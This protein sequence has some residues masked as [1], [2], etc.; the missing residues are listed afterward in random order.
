MKSALTIHADVRAQQR[1][2]SPLVVDLLLQFGKR[3]HDHAGA[4][5][6]FFDRRAKKDVESYTGGSIGKLSE[7]MDSY[8][9]VS[10]GCVITVGMRY[11]KINRR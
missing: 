3:E 11:K 8:A 6:V 9:V 2:I 7:Q 10:G 5:I 1:G 4:E